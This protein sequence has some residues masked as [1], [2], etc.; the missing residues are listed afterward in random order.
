[1]LDQQNRAGPPA[2]DRATR[3]AA[4]WATAIAVPVA[5]LVGLLFFTQAH[6]GAAPA[7]ATSSG[8][9]AAAPTTPVAVAAPKLPARAASVCLAVTSRLP[10]AVRSLA[11]RRVSAGPEQNAAYGEP[12]ITVACGVDRPRMCTAPQ[13]QSGCVPLDTELL[14][15]DH[16]CW[17]ADQQPAA[18]VFTTMDR[19][20]PVR[21]TVPNGY[22]QPAQWANEFSA[23]L[24]ATDPSAASG[25]PAGCR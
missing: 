8:A 4:L 18:A 9:P 14:L 22:G 19:A 17:Y 24:V 23:T 5:V 15:M 3:T 10:V 6:R 11:A 16:V 21:V 12:P 13:G 7:P 25:V 1:V 2:P 20:V